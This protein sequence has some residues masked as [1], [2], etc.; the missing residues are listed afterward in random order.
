MRQPAPKAFDASRLRASHNYDST[1][2][3][4]RFKRLS[5]LSAHE[6]IHAWLD[7]DFGIADPPAMISAIRKDPRITMSVAEIQDS[8][9]SALERGWAV[10][11]CLKRLVGAR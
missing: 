11:T 3:P 7:G 6:A 5:A 10:S 9:M 2:N 1:T 4:K 8:M